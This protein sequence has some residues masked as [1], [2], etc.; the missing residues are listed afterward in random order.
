MFLK[1]PDIKRGFSNLFKFLTAL[2]GVYFVFGV[3]FGIASVYMGLDIPKSLEKKSY[4]RLFA[5]VSPNR[6]GEKQ[7]AQMVQK[8]AEKMGHEVYIYIFDDSLAEF[9]LPVR[10]ISNFALNYLNKKYKPDFHLAMSFHINISIPDPKTMYI[11]VPPIF[12]RDK[13]LNYYKEIKNYDDFIDINL[14]NTKE[15]WLGKLLH[16]KVKRHSG[17]VGV[18]EN[19]YKISDRQGLL[20][21]GTLWG[22]N[23]SNFNKAIQLLA[24]EDYMYFLK[25]RSLT[26][27]PELAQ[28]FA[29][30]AEGLEA[31]Q[32]RLN[33]YGIG[34]CVHSK[35]HLQEGVPSS[36]IFEIISSGAIAITDKNPFIEKHFGDSVLYYDHKASAEEIFHQIDKNVKWVLSHKKEAEKKAHKA[37]NIFLK[38]FTTEKFTSDMLKIFP[39]QPN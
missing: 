30:N 1:M 9:F 33:H 18:P 28:Q 15:D 39:K 12:F 34:L 13:V 35:F 29:E 24:K 25:S 26:L 22:R 36:R 20:L 27:E 10:Y 11:S 14:I 8:A 37:H 17:I 38:N 31:L 7:Q 4:K 23:S 2:I 6:M 3:V 32:E 19:I 5:I 21:F 16:R